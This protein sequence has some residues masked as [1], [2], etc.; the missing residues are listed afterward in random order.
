MTLLDDDDIS[1]SSMTEPT[2]PLPVN[3]VH[4]VGKLS[5][6]MQSKDLPS[7]DRLGRWNLVVARPKAVPVDDAQDGDAAVSD[8][9]SGRRRQS[10]DTIECISF[11]KD[12]IDHLGDVEPGAQLEVQGALRRRFYPG[13]TGRQSSYSVE[14]EAV[15]VLSTPSRAATASLDEP[16]DPAAAA[17]PPEAGGAQ[18]S[19]TTVG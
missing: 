16:A 6:P 19:V 17:D 2:G 14:A 18:D 13:Q 5:Q 10:H 1:K 8:A 4:L 9:T 15:A 3:A 7:G 11:D 12:L